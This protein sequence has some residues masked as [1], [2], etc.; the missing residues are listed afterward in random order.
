MFDINK[1][2]TF[3]SDIPVITD[4]YEVLHFDEY[5]IL[6]IGTNNYGNKI[7]GS[8]LCEDE[9]TDT[10]RY[11][12]IQVTD[13]LFKDFLGKKTSYKN[14][15]L[16]SKAI[17]IVDKDINDRVLSTY[18]LPF[19]EIPNDYL[20]LPT[21]FC[22]DIN[23]KFGF[24]FG[25]SLKGSLADVHEAMIKAAY[26]V[27]NSVA[28]LIE[29]ALDSLYAL[30]LKPQ[31][32]QMP[33]T[34]GSFKINLKVKIPTYEN[35]YISQ[36]EIGEYVNKYLSYCIED[37][38][39]EIEQLTDKV[40]TNEERFESLSQFVENMYAKSAI[41]YNAESKKRLKADI[42][43]SVPML[44]KLADEVGNGFKEIE[45]L[46]I[47]QNNKVEIPIAY[48]DK[49]QS[50]KISEVSNYLNT[51]LEGTTKDDV[52]KDYLICIYHLNTDTRIGNA[53][54]YTDEEKTTM[55]KPK[56]EILGDEELSG[57]IYTESLHLN[58]WIKVRGMAQKYKDKF[59]RI[60]IKGNFKN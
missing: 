58:K 8:L 49:N 27:T 3:D 36:N 9:D 57:T 13:K 14:I 26:S 21:A 10:F 12:Q 30:K 38:P 39:N 32:H 7:I 59:K 46:G 2:R 17:F 42:I 53:Y 35:L 60:S 16:Q 31:I 1:N 56:I 33:Y 29:E 20:P 47:V 51:D 23:F 19:S 52:D 37:L 41:T 40:T 18:Y 25:I 43:D 6:F 15:I 54:I 55:D 22:P 4:N 5:P 34:E 50:K 45:I 24:E 11:L 28:G 44:E 48:I